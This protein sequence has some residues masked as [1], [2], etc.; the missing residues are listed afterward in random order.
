MA[1]TSFAANILRDIKFVQ[2][3]PPSVNIDLL[4]PGVHNYEIDDK[5]EVATNVSL[6]YYPL[7][8][9]EKLKIKPNKKADKKSDKKSNKNAATAPQ[10]CYMKVVIKRFKLDQLSETD[11]Q[12]LEHEAR[13]LKQLKNPYIVPLVSNFVVDD[14]VWLVMSAAEFGCLY[15]WSR[16]FGLE[17]PAVALAIKDV[18]KG[19]IS[20]Y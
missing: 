20:I 5:A 10:K 14:Q 8:E 19:K 12:L 18:L 16:P 7:S 15:T 9:Q 13:T 3:Y 6:A 2:T 17:E 4:K 1:S 11:Y